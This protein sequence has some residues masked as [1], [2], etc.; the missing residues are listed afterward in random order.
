MSKNKYVIFNRLKSR[1]NCCV[2]G[3]ASERRRVRYRYTQYETI[4]HE[5]KT[6]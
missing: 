2:T 6:N 4:V 3:R 5:I 1:Y